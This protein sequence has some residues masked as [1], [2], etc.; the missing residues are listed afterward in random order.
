MAKNCVLT[1]AFASLGFI[2][3]SVAGSQSTAEGEVVA[4]EAPFQ[5]TVDVNV[6]TVEVY[7]TDKRGNPITGLTRDDFSVTDSGEE[8]EITNFYASQ[9]GVRIGSDD[10]LATD[11]TVSPTTGP[12]AAPA[13]A[14]LDPLHLVVFIDNF[15]LTPPSRNRALNSLR[16]FLTTKVRPGDQVMLVSYDRSLHVRQPFTDDLPA[17]LNQLETVSG[18]SGHRTLR[19]RERRQALEDVEAAR[20]SSEALL[21]AEAYAD[22]VYT[23]MNFSIDALS[24][25]ISSLAGLPGRKA[26][27]YLSEGLPMIPGEDLFIAAGSSGPIRAATFDL[28]RRFRRLASI[29]SASRVTFYALDA[30]GLET[31][32]SVSAEEGGTRQG[33]GRAFVDSAYKANL[34]RPLRVLADATGGQAFLSSNALDRALQ[35]IDTDLQTYYS[36][37]FAGRKGREGAFHKIDVRVRGDYR[38]RHRTSYRNK[39][40]DDLILEGSTAALRYRAEYNA[41]GAEIELGQAQPR[42]RD[43]SEVPLTIKIPIAS[44]TTLPQ[45]NELVG[46]LEIAVSTIDVNGDSSPVQVQQPLMIRLRA[47]DI[48]RAMSQY[49]IY[50]LS[51]L[52]R[53]NTERIAVA[54]RDDI[55]SQNSFVTVTP[56]L[57]RS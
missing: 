55:R 40:T 53:N 30:R 42:D 16:R 39:S 33:G 46:R 13:G 34:H 21:A 28:S 5:E 41:I 44:I 4:A 31:H 36:L 47:D 32:A 24:D 23:E 11:T 7:V 43:T 25:F 12:A 14:K 19:V 10:S 37:G 57:P 1:V 8:V 26:L 18:L 9:D 51:L 27:V 15:H 29:A 6:V 17:L 50:D 48:E 52:M 49:Y 45:G 54:I 38:V 2:C 20:S 22:S 3:T 35:D 56:S